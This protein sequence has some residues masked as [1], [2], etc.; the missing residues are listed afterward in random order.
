MEYVLE[1]P[2]SDRILDLDSEDSRCISPM[3][4][5]REELEIIKTEINNEQVMFTE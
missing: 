1:S 3:S 2:S 5:L 4:K